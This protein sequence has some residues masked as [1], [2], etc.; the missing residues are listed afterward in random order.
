MHY[1][2]LDLIN[3][4]KD[5]YETNKEKLYEI[6]QQNRKIW[7]KYYSCCGFLQNVVQ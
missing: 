7:E 2:N 4:I 3:I 1:K 5:Y 6:Q